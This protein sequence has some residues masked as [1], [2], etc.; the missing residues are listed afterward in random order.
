VRLALARIVELSD[1][2]LLMIPKYISAGI[3]CF[4][5]C[6]MHR[7]VAARKHIEFVKVGKT[8]GLSIRKWLVL[9]RVKFRQWHVKQ[10]NQCS[11]KDPKTWL[12][13]VRDPISRAISAFN[14]R[15]P[16]NHGKGAKGA[17]KG[18]FESRFYEC[19]DTLDDFATSLSDT[20]TN[21]SF[22]ARE[23]LRGHHIHL[24]QTV[25]W[26]LAPALTCILAQD[27][28]LIRSESLERDLRDA[29]QFLH[30]HKVRMQIE[31]GHGSYPMQNMTN[32]SAKGRSILFKWLAHE[33][34]VLE[35]LEKAA[36]NG[37]SAQ[38]MQ[39]TAHHSE[40]THAIVTS[41]P[42]TGAWTSAADSSTHRKPGSSWL[43]AWAVVV[44]V[45]VL[46]A[47]LQY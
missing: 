42:P 16:K 38:A 36:A 1:L 14:W 15:S 13:S 25:D 7:Q 18:V 20:T 31:H 44:G 47:S 2:L 37:R 22:Y 6:L 12:I 43:W 27:I 28:V 5:G 41:P 45:P 39:S 30:I 46:W 19:F 24:G 8:G 23:M 3:L 21:C 10:V 35:Q 17:P 33:Y 34:E 11:A 29:A 9:N 4:V 26:Y 40:A 32:I